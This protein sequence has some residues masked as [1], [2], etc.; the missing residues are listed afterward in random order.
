MRRARPGVQPLTVQ[1][2]GTRLLVVGADAAGMTAAA[3]VRRLAPDLEIVAVDRGRWTSYSACGIPFLASGAVR[4]LDDLV[5]RS[6]EQFRA[7]RIDVRT[8]HEVVALDLAARRAEVHNLTHG[9]TFH[10]GF[11]LLLVATGAVPVRPRLDGFDLPHVHGVQT[12]DDAARLLEDAKRRRPE[13]IAVVGGGYI[14]LE[15]AEAF[16]ARGAGVTVL[17]A[18]PQ[19]MPS[20]DAD[21]AGIVARS[22]RE[23]G[24]DVRTGTE[25]HAVTDR[26]VVTAEGDVEAELVVLGTGVAPNS[27]LG[28]GAGLGTGVRGA[29]VVDRRQRTTEDGVW[30]A[31]D[32]CASVHLVSGRPAYEALGT[33]ANK[34][35]RVAGIN[36]AGGYATFPG[37][38]GTAVTRIGTLEVGRTGLGEAEAAAAGFEAAVVSIES[39]TTARYLPDARPVAV[40]LLAERGTGRVLG[41]Q[42]AGGPGA[43]KRVD[44][45]VAALAGRLGVEDLIGLDLSYAPP[46]S[47]VWDPLQVAARAL[48]PRV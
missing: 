16:S 24:I 34:Q 8:G 22:M 21:V 36:M 6:P 13:R 11:D 43:A 25:V 32:C 46:F 17:E 40:K 9:R 37:V 28:A 10:L 41:M 30:A 45:V 31:G 47:P 3:Q 42:T 12:L 4:G 7:A 35:G 1:R 44:V 14:G 15:M 2:M 20:L 23:M 29:L 38:M 19:I 18:G 48:L 39:T 27:A 33:V 26:A 5:V